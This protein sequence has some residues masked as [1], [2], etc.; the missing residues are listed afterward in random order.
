MSVVKRTGKNTQQGF[1]L[2]TVAILMAI[3]AILFS[4]YQPS[5]ASRNLNAKKITEQKLAMI[6]RAMT[7]YYYTNGFKYPCPA[8]LTQAKGSSNLGIATACS[9]SCATGTICVGSNPYATVGAP[10]VRNLGLNDDYMFDGWGKRF[11]Y[12]VD[13]GKVAGGTGN[14]VLTYT[15]SSG[16][17]LKFHPGYFLG[18]MGPNMLGGYNGAGKIEKECTGNGDS[19]LYENCD[20]TI[21]DNKDGLFFIDRWQGN[22]PARSFDDITNFTVDSGAVD[23]R[24]RSV[25]KG[26]TLCPVGIKGCVAWFDASDVNGDG[27]NP[28]NGASVETWKDKSGNG[29]D[30]TQGT[31]GARPTYQ[32]N[33]INSNRPVIRFD[34]SDDGLRNGTMHG[35]PAS[36]IIA[37]AKQTAGTNHQRLYAALNDNNIFFGSGNGNFTTFYGNDAGWN[38]CC[39]DNIPSSPI[40]DM[41]RI[42][43]AVSNGV[44]DVPYY[45]GLAQ[46]RANQNSTGIGYTGFGIGNAYGAQEFNGDVAELIIYNRALTDSERKAIECYLGNKYNIPSPCKCPAGVAGCSMW[47][48][49]S[50]VNANGTGSE[51]ANNASI[52]TWQDKSGYNNDAVHLGTSV[53]GTVAPPT[54]LSTSADM[55]NMPAVRFQHMVDNRMRVNIAT[56]DKFTVFVA[57]Y[58][59]SGNVGRT[60]SSNCCGPNWH[61]GSIDGTAAAYGA[62]NGEGVFYSGDGLNNKFVMTAGYDGTT[63]HAYKNGGPD[64]GATGGSSSVYTGGWGN[65]FLLGGVYSFGG[66]NSYLQ[67]FKGKMGDVIIYPRALSDAERLKVDCYLARKY[68]IVSTACGI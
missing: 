56:P 32:T 36:T 17:A 64:S 63:N 4:S 53:V 42:L 18:S 33:V 67:L 28:S 2:I 55:N 62:R 6:S 15:R 60:L 24:G 47:L 9:S 11:V 21:P 34:G 37:V 65:E 5:K 39:G 49:A 40:T 61:L 50:D 12:A 27:T 3:A 45:S 30:A 23:S 20:F 10:P 25:G 68:N 44:T 57:Y 51:P 7:E 38:Y 26:A 22:E 58:V 43:S 59:E 52:T 29:Y 16:E 8:S 31:S 13:R 46:T 1:A 48:D 19:K 41:F 14:P 66:E 54:L 35:T